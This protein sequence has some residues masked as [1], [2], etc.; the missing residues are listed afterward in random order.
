[1]SEAPL[2]PEEVEKIKSFIRQLNKK[3]NKIFQ[4][5]ED[6]LDQLFPQ[7]APFD[8]NKEPQDDPELNDDGR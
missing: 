4:Q 5:P 3:L 6:D 2:E 1:M 7:Y 8:E